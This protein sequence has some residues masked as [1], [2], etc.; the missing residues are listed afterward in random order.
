MLSSNLYNER[1]I[2]RPSNNL[3]NTNLFDR[4]TFDMPYRNDSAEHTSIQL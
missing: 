1:H 2:D 4:T 3:R